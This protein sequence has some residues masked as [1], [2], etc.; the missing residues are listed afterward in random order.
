M[1]LVVPGAAGW[2]TSSNDHGSTNLPDFLA[3]ILGALRRFTIL[4][5]GLRAVPTLESRASD[6]LQR[7]DQNSRRHRYTSLD[8]RI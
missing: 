2:V 7:P 5:S 4:G 6:T 8:P 1:A 3:V